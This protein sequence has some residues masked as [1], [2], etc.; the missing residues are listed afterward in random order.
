M[1]LNHS[2]TQSLKNNVRY[3]LTKFGLYM[4]VR[5]ILKTLTL[6]RKTW[7]GFKYLSGQGIEIGALNAPLVV[8]PNVKV[9]Y[10]DRLT[11]SQLRLQ[12]PE[13]SSYPIGRVDILDDGETLK[14]IKENSLDFVIA[15]HFL[16]HCQD[17]IGT[18]KN[19]L[20]VLKKGGILYLAIPDH[21][22]NVDSLISPTPLTHLISDHRS[23]KISYQ[24]HIYNWAYFV[25]KKRGKAL[26]NHIKHLININYS[27]HFHQWT[28]KE[29]K[30][31]FNFLQ[32]KL[33][34]PFAI[35]EFI[36]NKKEYLIIL[37]KI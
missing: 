21:R 4:P 8:L 10:L 24:K 27:I 1:S 7:L 33:H 35:K 26:S 13:L 14:T 15:H 3:L 31:F 30:E 17:P 37:K 18:I 2:I 36:F 5:A 28:Q 23:P 34:L 16:E 22:F 11:N 20:R 19:H 32:K 12:Y 6:D 25:D 9:K 29:L